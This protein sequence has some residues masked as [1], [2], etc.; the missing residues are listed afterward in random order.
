MGLGFRALGFRVLRSIPQ[1]I[2]VFRPDVSWA[3]LPLKLATLTLEQCLCHENSRCIVDVWAQTLNS[4]VEAMGPKYGPLTLGSLYTYKIPWPGGLVPFLV[5][6][7]A[8]PGPGPGPVLVPVHLS[9]WSGFG[10]VLVAVPAPSQR[11]ASC[12]VPVGRVP[13]PVKRITYAIF[14]RNMAV[15]QTTG[16]RQTILR[17]RNHYQTKTGAKRL[18]KPTA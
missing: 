7:P 18:P 10:A 14:S 13:V 12:P 6:C 11:I 3:L 5:S 15:L 9:C 8:G 16:E 2:I 1:A 4:K 17:S